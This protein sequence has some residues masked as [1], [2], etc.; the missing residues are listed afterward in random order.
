MAKPS[1]YLRGRTWWYRLPQGDGLPPLR[2]SL[3][4]DNERAAEERLQERARQAWFKREAGIDIAATKRR[5]VTLTEACGRYWT[6]HVTANALR[7]AGLIKR[8]STRAL[9]FFGRNTLLGEI[10]IGRVL[11]YKAW[12]K[13]GAHQGGALGPHAL[14]GHLNFVRTL[15]NRARQMWEVEAP[16]LAYAKWRVLEDLPELPPPTLTH[17][18]AGTVSEVMTEELLPIYRFCQI[19]AVRKD[20]AMTLEKH[21]VDWENGVIAVFQ[22]SKRRG[23]KLHRVI[24]TAELRVLLTEVWDQH[25]T[26]VFSYTCRKN[27][28]R[29]RQV[30]RAGQRYPFNRTILQRRW[31]EV[32]ALAK[33]TVDWHPATRAWAATT[34]I[35]KHGEA[36]AQ[37]LLGHA[38]RAMTQHYNRGGDDQLRAAMDSLAEASVAPPKLRVVK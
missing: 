24:L 7:S 29:G 27:W 22:K 12:L 35:A 30:R 17:A 4:T 32:R 20:N 23:G 5:Q 13:S 6:E 33:T 37:K 14:N 10:T 26:H 36:V 28:T 38:N 16:E 1:K 9:A 25:P 34:T 8:Y 18:E 15:L 19:T 2:G 3:E 31:D 11:A 21:Q